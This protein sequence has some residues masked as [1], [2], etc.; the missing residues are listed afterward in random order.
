MAGQASITSTPAKII[1]Q[2]KRV[3]S[4]EKDKAA[5][6]VLCDEDL[7]EYTPHVCTVIMKD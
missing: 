2:E 3:G 1:R 5:D 6:I 4:P 7:L